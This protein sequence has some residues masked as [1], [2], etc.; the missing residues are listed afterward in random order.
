[1][2]LGNKLPPRRNKSNTN[3]KKTLEKKMEELNKKYFKKI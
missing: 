2:G 3:K 1:M